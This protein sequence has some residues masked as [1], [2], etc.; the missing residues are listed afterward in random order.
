MIVCDS[1]ICVGCGACA[2]VCPHN[3]IQMHPNGEGFTEPVVDTENC[4]A[5]NLCKRVCPAIHI[6]KA[7]NFPQAFYLAWHKDRQTRFNSSSGGAFTALAK[8]I[9]NQNGY[10]IGAA[11]R[12][13]FSVCHV[14][15]SREADLQRLRKSKYLQSDTTAV[16]ALLEEL[17]KKDVPILFTGTPCQCA[18]VRNRFPKADQIV[19]CDLI[20][21][22][23]QS[24]KF[25]LDSLHYMEKEM[26]G[27]CVS[28]DFRSKKKGWANACTVEM[29]FDNG[30]TVNQR[31]NDIPVGAGFLR[32]LAIRK[33]CENCQYR[34]IERASDITIGDFWAKRD[35][36]FFI[37]KY[38]DL[39]YSSIIVNTQKGKLLLEQCTGELILEAKNEDEVKEQN[40]PLYKQFKPNSQRDRFFEDYQAMAY[41]T[42]H[43]KYLLPNKKEIFRWHMRRLGRTTGI[44]NLYYAVRKRLR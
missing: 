5:C 9:L 13:D 31:A 25:F 36:W 32:N 10:V 34:T 40:N 11:Y 37:K 12:E 2:S 43:N 27:K 38:G 42:L 1:A 44:R 22:G 28:I 29:V 18:A 21:H 17:L 15:V 39:G 20:C 24:P 4:V 23:V 41:E 6:N 19:T 35:D 3:C 33:A 8:A 7:E 16:F 30:K 26:D 14:A